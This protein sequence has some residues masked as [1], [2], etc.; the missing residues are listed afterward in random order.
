[1]RQTIKKAL[2]ALL[3]LIAIGAPF[4]ARNDYQVYMF[5]RGLI[6]VLVASG[7]VFLMGFAG[8]ISLGQA[9]FYCLGAYASGLLTS[10]SKLGL[11]IPAGIIGAALI[12]ML[13]GLILAFPSFKL[14]AFFLSLVTIAFGQIVWNLSVNLTGL[15]GGP[16]G[17]FNIPFLHVGTYVF[18][19]ISY[20]YFLLGC[21]VLVVYIMRRIKH[22]FLGRQ[23]FAMSDDEVAAETCGVNSKRMKIFAFVF[24]AALAG[25]A[26]AFYAHLTGFLT[27]EP[28]TSPMESANFLAMAIV[29]GLRQL[30]GGVIGGLIMTFL[31]ELLRLNVAGFENYYLI[32]NSLIIII[33][34][35]FLPLGLGS[36]IF[37]FLNRLWKD[38]P[39][40]LT[41]PRALRKRK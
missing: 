18:N 8:Q 37:P 2:Y 1:M 12:S 22:S 15:T 31:P 10:S 4:F 7:L 41:L 5:N 32:L 9:G 35:I 6:N 34:L 24:S 33:I 25:L 3:A 29:G 14:R 30:T 40:A 36:V 39:Q 26:G 13:A 38:K 27:P 20:F 21:V 11:P 23:L 28:F 19:N 17:L 16:G